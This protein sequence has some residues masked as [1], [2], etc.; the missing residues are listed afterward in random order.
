MAADVLQAPR[1]ARNIT[2]MEVAAAAARARRVPAGDHVDPDL[3]DN[4]LADIEIARIFLD[5]ADNYHDELIAWFNPKGCMPNR[6]MLDEVNKA[7]VISREADDRLVVAEGRL[8]KALDQSFNAMPQRDRGADDRAYRFNEAFI[9]YRD[10]WNRGIATY[11]LNFPGLATQDRP[12]SPEYYAFEEM[13]GPLY[14]AAR[15]AAIEVLLTPAASADDMSI[16]REVIDQQEM[17]L[18]SDGELISSIMNQLIADAI[19]FAGG[20]A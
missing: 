19:A 16:K 11:L 7:Q 4:A 8:R 12:A 9:P 1:I 18:A 5:A 10:A 13:M 20:A 3:I 14:T 17:F 6:A 15:D 2:N